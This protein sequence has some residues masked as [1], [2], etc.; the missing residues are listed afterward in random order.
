MGL[1]SEQVVRGDDKKPDW[2]DSSPSGHDVLYSSY[3]RQR[4]RLSRIIVDFCGSSHFG[5]VVRGGMPVK[6]HPDASS[7]EHFRQLM[8]GP[9]LSTMLNP[10]RDAH[11][12]IAGIERIFRLRIVLIMHPSL[13]WYLKTN[14]SQRVWLPFSSIMLALAGR[15]GEVMATLRAWKNER[16]A[17]S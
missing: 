12:C 1:Y 11:S 16:Q 9:L 15:P 8:A 6:S 13:E 17:Y 7:M 3:Q 14:S 2:I 4:S 5:H 10:P